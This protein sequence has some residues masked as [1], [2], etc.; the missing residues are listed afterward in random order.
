MSYEWLIEGK[1]KNEQDK[2]IKNICSAWILECI[3]SEKLAMNA[4]EYK[5]K[6]IR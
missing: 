2:K 5:N 6:I 1:G 4:E 3:S